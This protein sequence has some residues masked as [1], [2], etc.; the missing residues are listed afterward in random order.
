MQQQEKFTT[1]E[2]SG[3]KRCVPDNRRGPELARHS[4]EP[5][6]PVCTPREDAIARSCETSEVAEVLSDGEVGVENPYS[7]CDGRRKTSSARR[8]VNYHAGTS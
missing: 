5:T 2:G 4:R 8:R 7:Q 6:R 3:Y 1:R